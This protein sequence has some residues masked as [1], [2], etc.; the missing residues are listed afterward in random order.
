MKWTKTDVGEYLSNKQYRIYK[1]ARG[2]WHVIN[3]DPN[4]PSDLGTY[5]SLRQ[6]KREANE[7]YDLLVWSGLANRQGFIRLPNRTLD[8]WRRTCCGMAYNVLCVERESYLHLWKLAIEAHLT[9]ADPLLDE[10]DKGATAL[11]SD[12]Q[13]RRQLDDNNT[14]EG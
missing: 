10:I 3:G 11:A 1:D 13:S 4:G 7:H 2:G 14:G 8:V 6:A 12:D 9:G 5:G